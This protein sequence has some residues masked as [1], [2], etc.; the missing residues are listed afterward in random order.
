MIV[1]YYVVPGEI[2]LSGQKEEEGIKSL[3]AGEIV[4]PAA[5]DK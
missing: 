1:V 2:Y 4:W 3:D 5:G